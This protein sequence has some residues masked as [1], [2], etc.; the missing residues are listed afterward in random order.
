MIFRVGAVCTDLKLQV[1]HDHSQRRKSI[2][3]LILRGLMLKDI[4]KDSLRRLLKN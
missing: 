2:T 1:L 3:I 4:E